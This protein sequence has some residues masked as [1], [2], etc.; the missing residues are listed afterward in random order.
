MAWHATLAGVCRGLSLRRPPARGARTSPVRLRER[1]L[2]CFATIRLS[3]SNWPNIEKGLD[4]FLA[5]E[6]DSRGAI[7]QIW[8]ERQGAIP[9]PLAS[10]GVVQAERAGR[11]DR[12]PAIGRRAGSSTTRAER[13]RAPRKSRSGFSPQLTLEAAMLRRGGFEG[14][15]PLEAE[16]ALYLKL[17]G[18]AGGEEK[19]AGGK[20]ENIGE[21]AEQHFAGLTDAAR[22]V[23]LRRRR[24]ICRAR[25]PNSRPVSRTTTISRGSRNGRRPEARAMRGTRHEPRSR[26]SRALCGSGRP[27]P[28]TRR[29]RPG[30][31][32]TPAAAR[33]MS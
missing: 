29:P 5:F 23:R 20:D 26:H 21:L 19:H 9:V 8:V 17:G 3:R 10:G 7:A 12:R 22:R 28:R 11:P 14:L 25:S 15:P 24:P 33:P 27:G 31:P 32:P 4:F 1:A 30:S 18:A 2:R 16:E 13:R 6:R